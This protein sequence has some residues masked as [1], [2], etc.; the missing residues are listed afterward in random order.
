MMRLHE[1]TPDQER[2][3]ERDEALRD[4]LLN[5]C[6]TG[7]ACRLCLPCLHLMHEWWDAADAHAEAHAEALA[8]LRAM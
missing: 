2:A 4:E 3:H 7:T 1:H 6:E 5:V 8:E